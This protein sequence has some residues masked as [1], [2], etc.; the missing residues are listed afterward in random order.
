MSVAVEEA[1]ATP[2]AAAPPIARGRLFPHESTDRAS[3]AQNF[4]HHPFQFRH[5]LD[6]HPAFQLPALLAAAER[7]SANPATAGKSH[8]ESG[9]PDR[10]AWFGP[11]PEGT[12]L[13]D[14]LASIES[15]QN[16]VILNA[17]T[18]IQR[19]TPCCRKLFRS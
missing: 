14:A 17:F 2:Q 10:N 13:V 11:R 7:L 18:K 15:G 8:F 3:F 5:A 12:T 19:T 1:S 9:A 16:W 4:D 6:K